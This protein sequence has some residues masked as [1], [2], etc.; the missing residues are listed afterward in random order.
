MVQRIRWFIPM[1]AAM[2]FVAVV[3]P[4]TS[5]A[6]KKWSGA[7][8]MLTVNGEQFNVRVEWPSEFDCDIK[9]D[10][11]LKVF[12]KKGSAVNFHSESTGIF[13]G[14]EVTTKTKVVSSLKNDSIGVETRMKAREDFPVKTKVDQNG[15][16]IAE[17]VGTSNEVFRGVI[18]LKEVK[19][20][21]VDPALPP[22]YNGEEYT[23]DDGIYG[24]LSDGAENLPGRKFGWGFGFDKHESDTDV[25]DE[26]ENRSRKF[27]DGDDDEDDKKN[28]SWR[29][30]IHSRFGKR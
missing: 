3:V 21:V 4:G 2:L 27:F 15:Y 29:D 8:P 7:D 23:Y 24:S 17:F 1:M 6:G 13:N 18:S 5:E 30:R 28:G 12:V 19:D 22:N 16:W 26:D 14:C 25:D 11:S 10:I 9:G 20:G